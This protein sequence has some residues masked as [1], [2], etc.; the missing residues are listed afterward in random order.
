[1][2]ISNVTAIKMWFGT[3]PRKIKR[4]SSLL[5]RPAQAQLPVQ[6]D[7]QVGLQAQLRPLKE[8]LQLEMK[9]IGSQ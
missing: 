8:T 7:Q 4:E 1:L 5:N 6:V 9:G 3:T 2:S